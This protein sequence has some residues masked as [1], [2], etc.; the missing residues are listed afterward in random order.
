M[1]Q[2]D[3]DT[4]DLQRLQQFAALHGFNLT[5]PLKHEHVEK[6]AETWLPDLRFYEQE[7][8]H[9]IALDQAVSMVRDLFN[10]LPDND[11]DEW[12]LIL[13]VSTGNGGQFRKF[14]PPVVRV[15]DGFFFR[16]L[17]EAG[18]VEQAFEHPDADDDA[19]F[20]HGAS[21]TH[22]DKFFG[23]KKTVSGGE[24]AAA[25]DP[26]RPLATA[27][28]L[29]ENGNPRVDENGDEIQWPLITVLASFKNLLETLKYELAVQE[30]NDYPPDA[31]RGGFDIASLL[32]RPIS[33][34]PAVRRDFLQALI[35]AY[36]AN[37]PLEPVLQ[38]LPPGIELNVK[39]WRALT[40]FAFLE[41][42]F[43]YA[44]N[45]F[46]RVQTT[47]F[48]NEHEGD[49]EGCCLVFD[50]RRIKRAFESNVPDALL[51]VVPHSIITS[52]HEEAYKADKFSR[53]PIPMPPADHPDQLPRDSMDL[54]VYVAWTSQATYL[55]PGDH[56]LVDFQDV[57][58]KVIDY[59]PIPLAGISL[60]LVLAFIVSIIDHFIDTEDKTSHNGIHTSPGGVTG[61]DPRQAAKR[62]QV[63][64]MS[65]D[66]HIYQHG[67]KDLLRLRAFAGKWGGHDGLIDKSSPYVAKTGRYFRKLLS[68]L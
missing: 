63:M 48:E 15:R 61:D 11:Q 66:V 67:Q 20:T 68:Y 3:L 57:Y 19:V 42:D 41:Y 39:A 35:A 1:L 64:P 45:D 32:F 43:F 29:D 52:V 8:F 17:N 37:Q 2:E 51:R 49:N 46:N 62:V 58:D 12:R 54:A 47:P 55:T 24:V 27:P 25:G 44:Y 23:A 7:K 22:S 18:S 21:F 36:E 13:P 16:V 50:R 26:F 9:P 33:P 10:E 60:A 30:A 34:P 53:I 65:G 5:Q 38:G 40:Q 6:L 31:L 56:D 28:L 14:D 4:I 59:F